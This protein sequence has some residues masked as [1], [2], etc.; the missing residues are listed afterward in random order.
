MF[1]NK[2][3]IGTANFNKDYGFK[4]K[5]IS[6][7][8]LEKIFT[9]LKNKKINFFDTASS[10]GGAEKIIGQYKL[11]HNKVIT[12]LPKVEK[13][14]INN[15]IKKRVKKTLSDTKEKKLYA[16]LLHNASD[17]LSKKGIEIFKILKRFKTLKITS[18][19]GVSSYD[20][21]EVDKII[22]KYKID[23]IQI[24][25]SI[26]DQR[27]CKKGWI[28]KIKNK[29]IEIH[30][31]SIFLQGLLLEDLRKIDNKFKKW[32]KY[33]KKW[34]NFCSNNSISKEF[35]ALKFVQSKNIDKLV[36]GINS[37]SELKKNIQILSDKKKIKFTKSLN[38]EDEKLLNPFNW[39]L[40]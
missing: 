19:I 33:F 8:E 35:G 14:N 15:F 12:K 40:I 27:I 4:R 29:N 26:L 28:R 7:I 1:K 31:R 38:C 30:V 37:L 9:Y 34:D 23:I 39:R 11:S 3:V 13:K 25:L 17:L 36:I 10:Y 22:K 21:K 5:K 18:K 16:I 2:V 32:K 24:P 20:I 6:K